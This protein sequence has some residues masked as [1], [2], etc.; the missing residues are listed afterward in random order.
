MPYDIDD[1]TEARALAKLF[2]HVLLGK[3]ATAVQIE[4]WTARVDAMS[5]DDVCWLARQLEQP[6]TQTR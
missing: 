2:T 5:G 4:T 3:E 1:P 6:R